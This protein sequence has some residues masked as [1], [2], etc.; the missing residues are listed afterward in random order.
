MAV[1]QVAESVGILV[2]TMD[3]WRTKELQR[4]IDVLPRRIEVALSS[5]RT[6]IETGR[7]ESR[8]VS[9]LMEE[10]GAPSV[11]ILVACGIEEGA[12]VRSKEYK[13]SDRPG[14]ARVGFLICYT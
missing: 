1:E 10:T 9:D 14:S 7:D 5:K 2:D 6:D 13:V 11:L 3:T 4:G 8:I 12:Q